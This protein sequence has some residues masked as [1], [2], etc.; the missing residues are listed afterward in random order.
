MYRILFCRVCRD[1]L[2]IMFHS[3]PNATWHPEVELVV[4]LLARD[5]NLSRRGTCPNGR[6]LLAA[7]LLLS[8]IRSLA[9]IQTS[10]MLDFALYTNQSVALGL[11]FFLLWRKFNAIAWWVLP[12]ADYGKV[13][14][15]QICGLCH[16]VQLPWCKGT[17]ASRFHNFAQ[18]PW[19]DGFNSTQHW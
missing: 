12:P 15:C 11:C 9:V 8:F 2:D 19:A 1:D 7:L 18:A 17:I 5:T 3:P 14:P 16:V 4:V 13:D 10:N 6:D